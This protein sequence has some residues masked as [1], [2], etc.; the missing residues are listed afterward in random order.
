VAAGQLGYGPWRALR[1]DDE[2]RVAPGAGYSSVARLRRVRA[3]AAKWH[4]L[5]HGRKFH[6]YLLCEIVVVRRVQ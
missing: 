5:L 4:S 1:I 2:F 6:V 3:T